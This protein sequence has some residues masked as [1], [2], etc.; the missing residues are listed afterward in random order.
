MN[1]LKQDLMSAA[2]DKDICKD[3]YKEMRTR[4]INSLIDYY[5]ANPDWCMERDFPDIHTLREN[6]G[7]LGDKGIHVD[8]NFEGERLDGR[9]VYIFHNCTGKIRVGLN[10]DKA[11]IPM[12]YFGNGCDMDVLVEDDVIVPFYIIGDNDVRI[13]GR[14][15]KVYEVKMK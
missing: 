2:R 11:V 13:T 10:I 6:F 8:K 14:D 1:N 4:D 12:L 5:I 9:L 3:G 15:A 7:N